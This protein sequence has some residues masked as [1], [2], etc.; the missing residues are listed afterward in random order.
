MYFRFIANR[1]TAISPTPIA[2]DLQTLHTDGANFYQYLRGNPFMGSDPLGLYSD[3]FEM[4]DDF[5]AGQAGRMASH[6]LP[7]DLAFVRRASR[8]AD[9]RTSWLAPIARSHW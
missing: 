5:I 9:V 6:R 7:K 4:V 8:S 3:S 1:D 2:K